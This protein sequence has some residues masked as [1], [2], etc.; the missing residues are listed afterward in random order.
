MKLSINRIILLLLVG[1]FVYTIPVSAEPHARPNFRGVVI[2]K[3]TKQPIKGIWV[4]MQSGKHGGFRYAK[5]DDKGVFLF[6]NDASTNDGL[7]NSKTD[8]ESGERT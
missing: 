2:D 6:R 8:G 1:F 4:Q 5:T 7:A 3:T